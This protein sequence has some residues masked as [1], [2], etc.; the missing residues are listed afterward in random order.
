MVRTFSRAL[1]NTVETSAFDHLERAYLISPATPHKWRVHHLLRI[2]STSGMTD[3]ERQSVHRS[4]AQYYTAGLPTRADVLLDSSQL[5]WKAE[6][7][8]HYIHAGVLEQAQNILL[9]LVVTVKASGYYNLFTKLCE[10]LFP[11]YTADGWLYYHYAHCCF[12]VGRFRDALTAIEELRLTTPLLDVSKRVAAGRL[13]AEIVHSLGNPALALAMV[14]EVLQ[15]L[16]NE[17]VNRRQYSHARS[18][19]AMLLMEL[20]QFNEAKQIVGELVAESSER[21]EDLGLAVALMRR[22]QIA[23]KE[24]TA[25]SSIGDVI[26]ALALFRKCQDQRGTAWALLHYGTQL[27]KIGNVRGGIASI[28]ES[29]DVKEEIA[30]CSPDYW[31]LA[32]ELIPLVSDHATKKRLEREERRLDGL[33]RT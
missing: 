33:Y 32:K 4:Y 30:D 20:G 24:G 27:L 7:C 6:A 21:R 16:P 3:G 14:R 25:Q 8:K 26:N 12:I 18:V 15:S 31:R 13:H 11:K 17:R 2:L 22:F 19:E 9:H 29:L 10:E 23:T 28:R 5:L 1:F